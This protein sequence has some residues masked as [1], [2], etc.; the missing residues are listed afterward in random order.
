MIFVQAKGSVAT[1]HIENSV[2][3]NNTYQT[4][5]VA[6]VATSVPPTYTTHSNV[7]W[8]WFFTV[9]ATIVT[10]IL[11]GMYALSDIYAA[12]FES[13]TLVAIGVVGSLV[14]GIVGSVLFNSKW[15]PGRICGA[16]VWWEWFISVLT[17]LG[18]TIGFGIAMVLVIVVLYIFF[19]FLVGALIVAF[20]AGILSGG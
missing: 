11:L 7:G 13:E 1:T 8:F 12:V 20:I 5:Q 16:Y 14:S 15:A 4:K 6:A 18:F 19:Y 9:A 3:A 17:A 10:L 2:K